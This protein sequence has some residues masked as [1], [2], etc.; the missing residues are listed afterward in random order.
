MRKLIIVENPEFWNLTLD[1][2]QVITPSKYIAEPQLQEKG[3]RILNLC[4]SYQYQ[5]IG[6]YVSLLAE[7]RKHN[8]L[9]EIY[10]LQNFRY[11]SILRED[12]EDFDQ[13]IQTTFKNEDKDKV[14]F[15]IYLGIAR[16]EHFNRLAKQL[17]LYVQA[18]C[19]T[20]VFSKKTKWVLQSIRPVSVEEIPDDDRPLMRKA[21]EKFLLRKRDV[22][23]PDKKKYDLAILVDPDDPNPPSDEKAIQRF[24]KAADQAGFTVELITK[25][26]FADLIKYDALLIRETTFVNHHTFKFAKKA[27]SLGLAVID[28]SDS[29]LKCTNKVYL[30]ELLNANKIL[31]PKSFVISKSNYKTLPTKLAYPFILKQPDGAF[32]KGVFKIN[33]E[34]EYKQVCGSMFQKSE[35]LIAQEFL[36]TPFDWR[37]GI[38]DGKPLFVCKYFMATKHWQIVNWSSDKQTQ[39]GEVESI[40]VDQAPS[41]LIRTAMKATALI[42]RSL[43]GVDM[44]EVDGKFYVIEINDNPNID[45]GV[46]DKILKEKLYAKIMEVLLDKVKAL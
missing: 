28:D 25:N 24:I 11:P 32:S 1:D 17:F 5:S 40:P 14:E 31:T 41:G 23:Q 46:E 2:V 3:L 27:E 26:D 30:F 7:A 6:Y 19:L 18:P 44:K 12:F 35:L 13:L 10:T 43:Y 20:V 42:G 9:P 37:V 36:P 33:D 16:K 34:E 29:I 8:V 38:V 22:Q 45:A 4:K 39:E 15:D 21:V